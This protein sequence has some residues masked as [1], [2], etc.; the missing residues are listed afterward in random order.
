MRAKINIPLNA[1]PRQTQHTIPNSRAERDRL[2][3]MAHFYAL[4]HGPVPPVPLTEL[5]QHAV[6]LAAIANVDPVYNDFLLILLNNELWRESFAAIPFERRLL[7]LPKC[8]RA[9]GKCSAPI[10]DLG[11]ICQQCGQCSIR[12][13]QNQAEELGYAVLVAE[14]SATVMSLIEK[15]RIEAILGVSCMNVL[16]KAFHH[17]ESSAAPGLA[18]PL[19]QDDCC[20][21]Q[22]DLDWVWDYIHLSA[23]DKTRRL[24][25]ASLRDEVDAWFEMDPL[26]RLMGKGEGQTDAIARDWLARAGKRWRPFLT[27]AVF[28]ALRSEPG[29]LLTDSLRRAA[30]AVECFHKASLI[31][32]DIEDNDAT[33][34]GQKTL[35]EEHG[36]AV[37]LNAGDLLIGEGYRLL[38]GCDLETPGGPEESTF[39]DQQKALMVQV[40]AQGQQ[41]LCRGQGAE[42]LWTRSPHPLM[43]RDVLELF[44]L[45]TAPAFEVALRIGALCAGVEAHASTAKTLREFSEALG[46]AYQIRDDLEDFTAANQSGDLDRRRPNLL[47]A[48]AYEQADPA[49]KSQ[50]EAWLKSGGSSEDPQNFVLVRQL[51]NEV[52]DQARQHLDFHLQQAIHSLHSLENPSLKGLLRRIV[53]RI[54]HGAEIKSW[55]REASARRQAKQQA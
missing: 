10:D 31:H 8:L 44:R 55:C 52:L 2:R 13:L 5:R 16:E 20:N 12:D 40:A 35:H 54:F 30:V 9:D 6:R 51:G 23:S 22:V 11:L 47:L 19:L 33:R 43:P 3:R 46:I 1:V 29:P 25:L 50:L 34:Y 15:G 26:N 39:T 24:D 36:L 45:K 4:E 32:D 41:A 17:L 38:S 53:G 37:A 48:L 14:G 21:T 27:I 42:L 28:K 7:L 49:Q 18:V